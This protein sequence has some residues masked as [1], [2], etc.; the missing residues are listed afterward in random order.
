MFSCRRTPLPRSIEN[1]AAASVEDTT[2]PIRNAIGSDSPSAT[3]TAAVIVAVNSTATVA[4]STAGNATRRN[5]GSGVF[6]PPSKRMR[7]SATVPSRNPK[8]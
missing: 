7:T 6:S 2:L 5:T 8:A 1:T 4:N 3:P